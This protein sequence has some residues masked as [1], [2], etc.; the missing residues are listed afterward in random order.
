MHRP[1]S[2]AAC[3]LLTASAASAQAPAAPGLTLRPPANA[4]YPSGPAAIEYS[5]DR[6]ADVVEIDVIDA[7]DAVVVGWSGGAKYRQAAEAADRLLLSEALTRPGRQTVT[8]DLHAS[9]YFAALAEGVPPRYSPGP[10]VP[11]GHYVVRI[12]ALGQTSKQPLEVVSS[13][14]LAATREEDLRAQFDLAMQIRGSASAASR[15]IRRGR[16]LEARVNAHLKGTSDAATIESGHALLRRLDEILGMPGEAVSASAGVV[17]LYNGL[18]LLETQVEVAGRPTEARLDRYRVLGSA[19]QARILSLNS[20]I[21]GSYAR[22]ERGD[23][24]PPVPA[25]FGATTVKFDSKGVDFGPWVRTF[26]GTVNRSWTIPKEMASTKGRVVVTFVVHKSGSVTDILVATPSDFAAF[27]DSARKAIYAASL[28]PP[29]PDSFPAETCPMTVT[30]YFNQAAVSARGAEDKVAAVQPDAEGGDAP[31]RVGGDIKPPQRIKFVEA[32]YPS[33]AQSARVQGVV[34]IE[35]AI[36]PTG[37]V[38][39]AHILRSIVLLDQAALDAVKQWEFTPT[40][41]KG[42]PVPVI[43]TVSVA[44]TLQ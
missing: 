6:P 2:F 21:S 40:L 13:L 27:N 15:A 22:F 5:L 12:T 19:L 43:M 38:R 37:K 11:P 1:L 36:D 31:V 4:A 16:A 33:I 32:V 14:P 29:L 26:I 25:A 17:A 24:T 10:L 39:G 3:V 20:L 35:A 41:L 44:F 18:A 23:T 8:W 9:G 34:I 30:F 28:A 7:K 42:K